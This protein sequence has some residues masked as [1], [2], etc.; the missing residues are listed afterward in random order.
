MRADHL[1]LGANAESTAARYLV[2]QG[3]KLRAC[4]YRSR[5][6][7]I[8]LVMNDGDTVVFVEV[9]YRS[10]NDFGSAAE[11]ID[12]YKQRRIT[13]TAQCYSQEH[14]LHDE[15]SMR[16]DAV[17]IENY[18]QHMAHNNAKI[19]WLKDAFDACLD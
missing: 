17:L 13:R 8:D 10:R 7:E 5:W 4:N 16:F 6:G 9:R 2:Q 3:L 18:A 14:G 1:K 11:T 19:R 15:V 12:Y